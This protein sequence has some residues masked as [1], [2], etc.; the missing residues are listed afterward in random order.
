MVGRKTVD[1]YNHEKLFHP[2]IMN[3]RNLRQENPYIQQ[4]FDACER[5]LSSFPT[6]GGIIIDPELVDWICCPCCEND[7]SS[8]WIVKWGGRYDECNTCGHIYVKNRLKSNILENLY[9]DSIA[10]SLDRKVNKHAFNQQ[11]W[12]AVHSKYIDYILFKYG[13]EVSLLDVGCGGGE[14]LRFC[15]RNGLENIYG[16]D[17]YKGLIESIGGFLPRD[18]IFEVNSFCNS[19]L[20]NNKFDVITMWGVM[21][22]LTD[23]RGTLA[24]CHDYLKDNGTLVILFPNIHSRAARILGVTIPTINPRQHINFYSLTSFRLIA[25][26]NNFTE[27]YFLNELPVIDLMWPYLH[28]E[29][30]T[31]YEDI[32]QKNE[33]Y[34]YLFILEKN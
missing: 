21:E 23:P 18:N 2:V 30:K 5:E 33:S 7:T 14:F 25:S 24:K 10:D 27:K 1:T 28:F 11:Y 6:H 29:D 20:D 22:H 3:N 34:Y 17:I 19:A 32:V 16:L 8:Q 15:K 9:K 31:L 12:S 4:H 26:T 13:K